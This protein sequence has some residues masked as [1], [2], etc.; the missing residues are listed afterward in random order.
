MKQIEIPIEGMSC[1]ACSTRIEKKVTQMEGAGSARVNLASRVLYLQFDDSRLREEEVRE[2]IRKL[3]YTPIEKESGREEGDGYEEKSMVQSLVISA[4]LT[5]PLFLAMILSWFGIKPNLL[6]SPWFQLLLATP[7]QF[8]IGARFYRKAWAGLISASPGMDLLVALGTSAAYG[9]SIYSGFFSEMNHGLYFETSA[10]LI[11][12]ILLGNYLE[13][14]ARGRAAQTI[15]GLLSRQARQ[16]RVRIDGIDREIPVEDVRPDQ[17]I[18]MHPGEILPVDGVITEGYSSIDESM[19][20]G[21]GLPA[22]RKPG[23]EVFGSTIN[24][25]GSFLYRATGVGS[26]TLLARIVDTVEKAQASHPPIQRLADRIAAWFVPVVI[27]IALATSLTWFFITGNLE[28]ALVSGVAVVVISCPCALGIATP[29][30]VM[31]AGGV[32]ARNGILIRKGE[33]LEWMYRP[34]V[35]FFDKTG[36][37][38]KGH[39]TLQGMEITGI[40]DEDICKEMAARAEKKSEHPLGRAIYRTLSDEMDSVEDPDS[41]EALPGRGVKALIDG[42]EVMALSPEGA[43]EMGIDVSATDEAL[44]R[45]RDQGNTVIL[46]LVEGE[47][48]ALFYLSDSPREA[49]RE[50]VRRL[51]AK[52]VETVMLTGDSERTARALNRELDVDSILAGLLPQ[53]KAEAINRFRKNGKRTLMVGDGI[54]DAP[55]LTAADIG[56]AMG[57]GSDIALKSADVVIIA[58]SPSKVLEAM[59]LSRLAMGKVR[60]NLFWAFIY[61]IIGIP[62]AAAGLLSPIVAGTAMAFSSLSVIGNSLLLGRKKLKGDIHE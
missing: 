62:L 59:D 48:A 10:M 17:I 16:A 19:I 29:A 21:E 14:K 11:T 46:L 32:G 31:V 44:E 61:N 7:V 50:T 27:V 4:L 55:A 57:Q 51:K 24:L 34:D 1:T 37:L 58:D 15:R 28:Q 9:F 25:Y 52:G 26:E 41:F 49:A 12:I 30:A 20:T 39:Y 8:G 33:S 42:R 45:L 6:H 22:E 5:L 38:T 56:V 53:Q 18:V 35:V 60:L 13:M 40:L 23:D 36:T 2:T 47:I 3:G 54:N 43:R